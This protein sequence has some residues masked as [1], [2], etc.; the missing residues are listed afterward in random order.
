MVHNNCMS[1]NFPQTPCLPSDYVCVEVYTVG[2]GDTLYS[3][4]QKYGI[5]VENVDGSKPNT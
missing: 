1:P 4:S 5:S 2:T 3:I